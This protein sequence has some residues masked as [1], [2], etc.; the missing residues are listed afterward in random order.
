MIDN[1]TVQEIGALRSDVARDALKF[2]ISASRVDAYSI[3]W[4]PTQAYH[5][6]QRANRLIY[7]YNNNDLVGYLLYGQPI[8]MM[9]V[10][11]IWVRR[12]ARMLVHG[13]SLIEALERLGR[14]KRAHQTMLWCALD[15]EANRFWRALSFRAISWRH[16]RH[17][18][19]RRH[20]LWVKPLPRSHAKQPSLDCVHETA[21]WS[22][23]QQAPHPSEDEAVRKAQPAH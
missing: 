20:A 2:A 11:Q 15:L 19:G 6:A 18:R 16:S 10:Y 12:D 9:Q 3:G 14:K 21:L 1:I 5:D 22:P 23:N 4:L 8:G 17:L 13:R 7:C